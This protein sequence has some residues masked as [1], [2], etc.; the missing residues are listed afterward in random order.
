MS[1]N[2]A[3]LAFDNSHNPLTRE[4]SIRH[5]R[6]LGDYRLGEVIAAQSE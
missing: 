4:V 3:S 5:Q 2:Q 1:A 6:S